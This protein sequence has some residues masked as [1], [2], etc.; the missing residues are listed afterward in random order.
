MK[1]KVAFPEKVPFHLNTTDLQNFKVIEIQCLI[2]KKIG[3]LK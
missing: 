3:F 2:A 1:M